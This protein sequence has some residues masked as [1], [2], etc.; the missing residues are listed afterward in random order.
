MKRVYFI[1]SI[2]LFY[3]ILIVAVFS[4][5]AQSGSSVLEPRL[6]LP[7]QIAVETAA[8]S[9]NIDLPGKTGEVEYTAEFYVEANTLYVR[10]FIETTAL[11]V[12]GDPNILT[13]AP[14]PLLESAG[15]EIYP[16]GAAAMPPDDSIAD[17]VGDGDPIGLLPSKKTAQILFKSSDPYTFVHSVF[18]TVK[19]LQD[20]PNK[21]AGQY[22]GK[23]KLSC[24]AEEPNLL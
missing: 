7:L 21:P 12:N 24:M 22:K 15:V 2:L 23:I 3:F 4:R 9:V 8:P 11:Y 1:P 17:Y 19:W 16:E 20:D 6:A 14:I 18:A 13:V 10:M 5:A